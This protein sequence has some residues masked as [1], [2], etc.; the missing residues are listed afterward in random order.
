MPCGTD[1]VVQIGRKKQKGA[2][3][4]RKRNSSKRRAAIDNIKIDNG[5][6]LSVKGT[7]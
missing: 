7:A 2:G 3:G 5:D 6:V 1:R 4:R